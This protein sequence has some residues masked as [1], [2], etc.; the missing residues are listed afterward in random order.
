MAQTTQRAFALS[1]AIL[2]I[3]TTVGFS[4]YVIWQMYDE[5]KN[6]TDTSA[7]AQQNA[8]GE[9]CAIDQQNGEVEAVP[10][11]Y[12]PEGDVT[13]LQTVDLQVGEGAEV[14][15]G[16]CLLVKYNGTLAATGEQFDG[17]FDQPTAI[18]FALGKGQVIEG[19]DQ[20]LQGMKV[21]GVR[22]IVIPSELAYRD[23]ASETIPA[24]SDLVFVVKVVGVQ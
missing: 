24:N 7:N 21:G 14:K 19:W 18:Q 10:E 5:S 11:V 3:V 6:P 1:L 9:D 16:D 12:K 8:Q 15:D 13:E 22:R 20:G 2:F 4:G 23:Q 17:N